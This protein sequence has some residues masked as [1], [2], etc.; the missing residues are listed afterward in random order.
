MATACGD[1]QFVWVFRDRKV[2][3]SIPFFG[4]ATGLQICMLAMAG[5]NIQDPHE[6][7]S[8]DVLVDEM[9][10]NLCLLVKFTRADFGLDLRAW[11]EF[12]L[13]SE[14]FR[15]EYTFT[16]AWPRVIEAIEG[17]LESPD[18]GRLIRILKDRTQKR[19]HS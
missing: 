2:A 6:P 16:Y 14:E 8:D 1:C 19:R 18:R 9:L 15:D 10:K 4:R 12:L 11:H 17:R 3:M 5:I 7:E 13:S